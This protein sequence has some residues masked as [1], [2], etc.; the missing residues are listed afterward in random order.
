MRA[1]QMPQRSYEY[2]G[3]HF[4]FHLHFNKLYLS[5]SA[6]APLH[7]QLFYI[8]NQTLFYIAMICEKAPHYSSPSLCF[9]FN[10][11]R[12]NNLLL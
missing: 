8:S 10:K 9:C 3:L 4:Y 1:L 7:Q 11:S 12:V 6:P 5:P 2:D